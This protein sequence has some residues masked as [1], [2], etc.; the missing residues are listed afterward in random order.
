M[1]RSLYSGVSGLRNHQVRMDVLGNNI[2][3]VNTY[4]FKKSRV[5]FQD[6]LSQ[7]ISGAAAPTA[8]KGG[9]NP[10]QVGLGM[11][12][13]SIDKIFTQGS[14]Q[15]TGLNLDLAFQGDGFF[16]LERG[17]ELFYTRAGAF[18]LD[19]G[20]TLVNPANGLRVKGWQAIQAGTEYII[21]STGDLEDIIIPV[22]GKDPARATE[23]VR[24]K[25]NLNSDTPLLPLDRPPSTEEMLNATVATNI[26]VYDSLGNV[27]VVNLEFVRVQGEGNTW[28]LTASVEGA[29]PD[30]LTFDVGGANVNDSNAIVMRFNNSGAPVS[31]EDSPSIAGAPAD[32]TAE[33]QLVASLNVTFPEEGITQTIDLDFGTVGLY[34]GITQFAAPSSVKAY[35]QDGYGLGYLQSFTVDNSGVITGVYTNGKKAPIA[36]IAVATFTNPQGLEAEGDN[37]FVQTNNS[38]LANIGPAETGGRGRITAGTLEMSNVDLAEQFTDMIVTQRGFQAN[39]RSITTSDQMLQEL[40]TLKR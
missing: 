28:T 6:I 40:L 35:E 24:Y 32:T 4:G 8:E 18:A 10:K 25:S 1:M 2:A 9:V 23:L 20:G 14:L 19:K 5:S 3:N 7:T 13:A 37:F 15:T 26:D 36:Q 16:I 12:I 30:M 29:D 31:I 22:G 39:S 38:G 11:S 34:N 27:H 33:G 17:E 21:N